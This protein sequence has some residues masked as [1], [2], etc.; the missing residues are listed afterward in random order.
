MI[1]QRSQF[2]ELVNLLRASQCH[3]QIWWVLKN[4]TDRKRFVR[5]MNSYLYFFSPAISAH[6]VALVTALFI[7]HD[8]DERSVGIPVLLQS[9]EKSG[10]IDRANADGLRCRIGQLEPLLKKLRFIRHKVIAHRSRSPTYNEAFRKASLTP[11]N[12]QEL[13]TQTCA[14]LHDLGRLIGEDVPTSFIGSPD[15][16]TRQLLEDL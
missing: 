6:F 12:L 15:G 7:F 2:Q 8:S 9:W 1:K 4:E 16:D 13:L 5:T 11:D 10:K 3:F 14:I